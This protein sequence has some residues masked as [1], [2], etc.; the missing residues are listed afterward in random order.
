[1]AARKP[2]TT[3]DYLAEIL[4]TH[5]N[6]VTMEQLISGLRCPTCKDSQARQAVRDALSDGRVRVGWAGRLYAPKE[7]QN[8]H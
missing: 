2:E 3:A 4:R 6:G 1:M 8:E 7:N 5:P